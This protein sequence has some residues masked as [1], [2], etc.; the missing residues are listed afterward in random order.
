[1]ATLKKRRGKWYAR[2]LWYE[3]TGI[4]REKQVPLRTESKVEAR[5]RLSQVE[6]HRNEI[7]ELSR[8]GENY[9]FPW[10][11]DDGILKIDV[12]TFQDAI[13]EW[14]GLRKSQGIAESTINRNR[15]SMN[16]F[17][18]ILGRNIR[19]S[20]ITTKSIEVY[21]DTMQKRTH[22]KQE[23]RYRP[24]GININLRT[25]RTF[26]NWS[27]RRNYIDSLP[28]FS[29][30]KTDKSLPSYISDSDFAKIM[31]LDWLDDHH[32]KAFQF[33]R[34][35]G[36]RLSEPFIGELSGTVLVIP[37]KYSKSR[38]EKEIEI[39][40]QYL[41]TLLEMQDAYQSWIKKV[42]KPVL[43]YFTEKYSKV[44]KECCR[45]IGIDRRFHDLR[46]TFAVRR[47]LIT[48]D[49]YQ[50]MKEIW[51]GSYPC[52]A[53]GD[54]VA[55]RD[56]PVSTLLGFWWGAYVTGNLIGNA[57]LRAFLSEEEIEELITADILSLVTDVLTVVAGTLVFILVSQITANQQKKYRSLFP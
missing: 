56:V 55:R 3:N 22:G 37:A 51:K 41:P 5:S 1:M 32:R 40:I 10:M 33:F 30:V 46:H 49:I 36:C 23:R 11:N 29:M 17:T 18:D 43:K 19:L 9:N 35:T 48:R 53:H 28:Y 44:F 16:T 34:D 15:C 54:P 52:K 8:N 27:V 24:N 21:T 26:L 57:T 13:D 45:T 2:V 47:Y 39:D 31:E 38:M 7:V 42:N 6:K 14:L 4:R 12:F 50:V 25:L 20:E